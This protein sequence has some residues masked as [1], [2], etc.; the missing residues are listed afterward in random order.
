MAQPALLA[1]GLFVG[2]LLVVTA[3]W[4]VNRVD[5]RRLA[6]S[7]TTVVRGIVVPIG[8]G[9]VALALATTALGWWPDVLSQPR[10]GP[11]WAW[12]VPNLLLLAALAGCRG[13]D[14][15]GLGSTRVA[16]LAAAT[17]VIGAAEELLAR[18]VLVVGAQEAGWPLL[19][20]WLSSTGLFALLHAVNALFGLPPQ[21]MLVQ[22]VMSFLGGTAFFVT[23]MTTGSLLTGVV[24]HALWDFATLGQQATGR[25]PGRPVFSWRRLPTS[26]RSRLPGSSASS[27]GGP[28]RAA[29]LQLALRTPATRRCRGRHHPHHG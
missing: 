11:A 15:G 21:A 9:L 17:L 4:R 19:A 28:R 27:A 24:L 7:N 18:G 22:L 20:V 12:V 23:L 1:V 16:T 10:T 29:S 13:V 14:F 2:Y 8:A 26:S 25:T 3:L 5:Y 6:Q